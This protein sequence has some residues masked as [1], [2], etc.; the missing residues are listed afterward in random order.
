M[1]T[2]MHA[3]RGPRIVHVMM[4]MSLPFWII[5]MLIIVKVGVRVR[6][7]VGIRIA[8]G[9]GVG[10]VGPQRLVNVCAIRIEISGG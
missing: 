5:V 1:W 4:P 3:A 7:R 10:G 8:V 2:R 9:V 6:I